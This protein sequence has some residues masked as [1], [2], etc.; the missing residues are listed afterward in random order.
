MF[1]RQTG[2][3]ASAWRG[4]RFPLGALDQLQAAHLAI[5]DVVANCAPAVGDRFHGGA[6]WICDLVRIGR[7]TSSLK[8]HDRDDV[9]VKAHAPR[10][11]ALCARRDSSL[12]WQVCSR[13]PA[14]G[15]TRLM[16]LPSD[17]GALRGLV[18]LV[19]G[20]ATAADG[21]FGPGGRRDGEVPG[22]FLPGRPFTVSV[23]YA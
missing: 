7:H 17:R 8:L 3:F 21:A 2:C 10:P 18:V 1:G 19:L 22:T 14:G 9:V 15:A 16:G 20:A 23:E 13:E 12:A 11:R 5:D 4:G 6:S